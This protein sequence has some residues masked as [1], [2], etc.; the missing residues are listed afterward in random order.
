[1]VRDV[2]LWLAIAAGAIALLYAGN[3][4]DKRLRGRNAGEIV[5]ADAAGDPELG[6]MKI[7]EY[8]CGSCHA[9]RGVPGAAGRVGPPLNDLRGRLYLAGR[10]QNTTG[11]LEQWI[12]HP[13]E[14][15]PR[16][17]M[18]DTGVTAEDARHMSAYLYSLR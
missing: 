12:R 13:R 8:G 1:M 6:R 18:P 17:V 16:T 2:L 3:A 15:D 11:N 10:L 14:M 7:R 5:H 9:V 4:A